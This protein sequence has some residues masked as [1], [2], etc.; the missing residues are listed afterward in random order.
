MMV[1]I[2]HGGKSERIRRLE[3]DTLPAFGILAEMPVHRIRDIMEFLVQNGFLALSE[4]EYPV[5]R[6]TDLSLEILRGSKTVE[7]K[8]PTEA[9]KRKPRKEKLSEKK[10]TVI[11]ED[12]ELLPM[13]KKLRKE[14]ASAVHVPAYIIFTDATLHDMCKRL[15]QT[16]ES[17]QEVSGVGKTKAER[18]GAQF[19]GLIREYLVHASR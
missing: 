15:P 1:D 19:T 4:G 14:L 9:S 6:L 11:A 7:M 8:L 17:F 3:L 10:Q 13:L 12:N 2:L 16:N 5:V 18:Y